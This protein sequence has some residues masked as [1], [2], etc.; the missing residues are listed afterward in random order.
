MKINLM[1][2]A[3]YFQVPTGQVN[4]YTQIIV[5]SSLLQ[6]KIDLTFSVGCE[7]R[8]HLPASAVEGIQQALEYVLNHVPVQDLVEMDPKDHQSE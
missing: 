5:R 3:H 7:D 1:E 8:E 2:I 6:G 4:G